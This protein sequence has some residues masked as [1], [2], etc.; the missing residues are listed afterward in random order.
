MSAA[1]KV[2]LPSNTMVAAKPAVHQC[3]AY[4]GT[5]LIALTGHEV[6]VAGRDP[7][8]PSARC[9]CANCDAIRCAIATASTWAVA[10]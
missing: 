8:L 10:M 4:F 6:P 2:V 9:R 3:P 5:G 7:P 1:D